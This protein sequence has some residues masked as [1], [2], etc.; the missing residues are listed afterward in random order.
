MRTSRVVVALSFAIAGALLLGTTPALVGAEQHEGRYQPWGTWA[1]A[2]HRPEKSGGGTFPALITYNQDGTLTGSDGVM[3]GINYPPAVNPYKESGLHGVWERTGRHSFRGTS[4]WM[5]F[6][7]NGNVI[8]LGRARSDLHFAPGDPDHFA[9]LMFTDTLAC[10]TP[11]TCPDPVTTEFTSSVTMR[12][13]SATR[14][15]LVEPPQM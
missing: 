2:T 13:V 4:Y 1:W 10:P 11:F 5:L 8:A 15:S 12:E 6:D 7:A 14:V 9:G 3:Y